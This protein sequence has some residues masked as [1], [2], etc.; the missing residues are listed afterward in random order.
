MSKAARRAGLVSVHT[1]AGAWVGQFRD[2]QGA[3]SW[4]SARVKPEMFTIDPERKP[5][6]ETPKGVYLD[7][8]YVDKFPEANPDDGFLPDEVVVDLVGRVVES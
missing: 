7:A 1:K 6:S 2:Q 3:A 4:V 8:R 5:E